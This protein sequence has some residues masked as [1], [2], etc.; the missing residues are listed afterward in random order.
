MRN[1]K[2]IQILVSDHF[3]QWRWNPKVMITFLLAL[4]MC[5][6]L[7]D[8]AI[9]FSYRYDTLL[10]ITEVFVWTFSDGPSVLISTFLIFI[11]FAD[12]PFTNGGTAYRVYRTGRTMWVWGNLFY[13]CISII[14]YELFLLFM[15][16]LLSFSRSFWGNQ[17]S[18][19]AAMI[20][21][22]G[23]SEQLSLFTSVRAMEHSAPYY[24]SVIVFLLVF[25]YMYW[26]STLLFLF[27]L[28]KKGL[29]GI[30]VVITVNLYGVLLNVKILQK[31]FHIPDTLSYHANILCGWLS[32]LNHSLYSMH[33]FG[34]DRLPKI[35]MSILL[36]LG[37]IIFNCFLLQRVIQKYDFSFIQTSE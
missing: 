23:I 37:L 18:E 32:P 25:L 31:I 27:H 26:I 28:W 2:K 30:L 13:L 17:W 20:G 4:V 12:M 3:L 6:M 11:L 24:V 36:L 14:L 16:I 5:I 19:T 22:G 34:Y 21:Y 10:Q 9:S 7:T 8:K 15:T 1:F 29:T 35:W 33:S